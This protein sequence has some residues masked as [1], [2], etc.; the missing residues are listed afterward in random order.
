MAQ[1]K[2]QM[3]SEEQHLP[4]P[5]KLRAEPV[6][7]VRRRY[8]ALHMVAEKIAMAGMQSVI[9]P[10]RLRPPLLR[11]FGARIGRNVRI[12]Q[13]VFI[14]QPSNLTID[15]DV[16]INVGAF[17]DCSAPV[18]LGEKVRIGYQGMVITGSHSAEK[19]VYRRKE[20]NHV[21]RPVR[22]E[23]G[24]WIQSRS[25][26]GPGVT[27]A[28][29]CTLLAYAVLLDSTAAN[30]EYCGIP[31]K[32]KRDLSTS[33]DYDWTGVQD[34]LADLRTAPSRVATTAPV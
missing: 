26:I 11:L 6:G 29:G 19:S 9:F 32:R 30:G 31:A 8:G 27:M 5:Q 3:V 20:G 28:E 34:A 7:P 25:M 22:V 24:C 1:L 21:R 4:T 12:A 33:D 17:I 14:G 15:D 2:M 10:A 18:Y 13:R 16:M 23:R